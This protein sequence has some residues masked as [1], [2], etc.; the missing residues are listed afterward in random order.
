MLRA[1]CTD[2]DVLTECVS[3]TCFS[4]M[5][6]IGKGARRPCPSVCFVIF[7]YTIGIAAPGSVPSLEAP[8][9]PALRGRLLAG[10]LPRPRA[11]SSPFPSRSRMAP[12]VAAPPSA[13]VAPAAEPVS[14][15]SRM[16]PAVE[17][18]VG[19]PPDPALLRQ[20]GHPPLRLHGDIAPAVH[21]L[22]SASQP[23]LLRQPALEL[24]GQ[25][26]APAPS[27]RSMPHGGYTLYSTSYCLPRV[28]CSR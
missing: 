8:H 13:P 21:S 24:G 3:V 6:V 10:R 2:V 25:D 17:L 23:A 27:D 22:A 12:A 28:F 15:A 4:F 20:P 7:V 16:A 26:A 1:P 18:A 5:F 11:P 9:A 19:P 14:S